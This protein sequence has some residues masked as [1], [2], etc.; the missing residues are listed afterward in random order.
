M[1]RPSE[2][3][4]L[5]LEVL[6]VLASGRPAAAAAD[7]LSMPLQVVVERLQHIRTFYDVRST[8]AALREAAA[9]GHLPHPLPQD[10]RTD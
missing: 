6:E 2:L 8:A 7:R 4:P 1:R 9:R 5:D 3:L 10:H